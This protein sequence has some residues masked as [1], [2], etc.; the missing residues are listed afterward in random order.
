M[1][2]KKKKAQERIK[3]IF[4]KI[5]EKLDISEKNRNVAVMR[6]FAIDRK[7]KIEKDSYKLLAF[8]VLYAGR[9]I[10]LD[11]AP[12]ID[13]ITRAFQIL[14]N[15]IK[16]TSILITGMKYLKYFPPNKLTN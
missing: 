9:I 4:N 7:E 6:Y 14:D 8:C 15:S 1:T 12:K 2:V 11:T 16:C 3:D 5:S 13:D 10:N